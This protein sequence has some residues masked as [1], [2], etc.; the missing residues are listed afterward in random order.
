MDKFAAHV[1]GKCIRRALTEG[2]RGALGRAWSASVPPAAG[3]P[4]SFKLPTI[5]SAQDSKRA[6]GRVGSGATL[7]AAEWT[8]RV[9]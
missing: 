4:L 6:A 5:R 3:P 7:A 9:C 2:Y 8:K 1:M